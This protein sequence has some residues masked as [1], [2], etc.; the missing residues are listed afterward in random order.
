MAGRIVAMG[1]GG[2]SMPEMGKGLDD[3][4]LALSGKAIP[5]VCFIGT[6]SGDSDEYAERFLQAFGRR[7]AAGVL[8]LFRRD[9]SDL[10]ERLLSQDIIYVG[11]GNTVNLLALWRV[12]GLDLVLREVWKSG[13]ILCGLSA[14]AICW[15]ESGVTDSF[16]PLTAL[17]SGLGFLAGSFCPHYDGVT[18]RRPTY[19][20]LVQGGD[21]AGGYA[22]DD[23]AALHYLG[24][25]MVEA[26]S[27]RQGATA[28]RVS[29]SATSAAIEER[30]TARPV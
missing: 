27:A 23:G 10:R 13:A 26:I 20:R 1:G 29:A 4:I 2:F 6:A 21:I 28:Y 12:H 14:G 18:E 5:K 25:T 22:V 19:H 24:S 8:S 16:G 9:G 17:T 3:Y 15:F 7:T 30:L 11:G